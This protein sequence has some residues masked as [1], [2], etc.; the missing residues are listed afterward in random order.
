LPLTAAF[1]S[2]WRQR[3][4]RSLSYACCAWKM[5]KKVSSRIRKDTKRWV[6][7]T[8]WLTSFLL[9]CSRWHPSMYLVSFTY[10]PFSSLASH[11]LRCHKSVLWLQIR[12]DEPTWW[13]F[14]WLLPF[15]S[16]PTSLPL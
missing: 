2:C 7:Q 16:R 15:S 5:G 9:C 11:L 13:S 10:P 12:F 3:H 1:V 14:E 8:S 6:G 4:A